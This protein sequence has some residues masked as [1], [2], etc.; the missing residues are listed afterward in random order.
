MEATALKA[1][2]YQKDYTLTDI[3]QNTVCAQLPEL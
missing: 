2:L 1:V 3:A